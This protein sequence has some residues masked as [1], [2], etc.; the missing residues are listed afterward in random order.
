[1]PPSYAA[2]GARRARRLRRDAL[3]A[4]LVTRVWGLPASAFLATSQNEFVSSLVLT[5][6]KVRI[7]HRPPSETGPST[8]QA[9]GRNA[10]VDAALGQCVDD[11]DGYDRQARGRKL[12]MPHREAIGVGE[13]AERE[14]QREQVE[15]VDVD[16]RLQE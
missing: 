15:I 10:P 3:T 9:W 12:Q 14:R 6:T 16:E 4:T 11:Q 5:A 7:Q 13:V 2:D 8:L 1:M